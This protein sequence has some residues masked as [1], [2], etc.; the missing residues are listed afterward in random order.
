[1]GILSYIAISIFVIALLG[2][3][4]AFENFFAGLGCAIATIFLLWMG[5]LPVW[6][7]RI[8]KHPH[9]LAIFLINLLL[10]W[11]LLFWLIAIVWA[12][13]GKEEAKQ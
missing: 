1:M 12:F 4:F 9:C 8:R 3:G 6:I 11:T 10:G 5:F 13:I 7:A 2:Y